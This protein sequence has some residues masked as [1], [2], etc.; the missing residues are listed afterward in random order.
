MH[1]E[2]VYNPELT[3][4][5]WECLSDVLHIDDIRMFEVYECNEI[6]EIISEKIDSA[7]DDYAYT[8]TPTTISRLRIILRKMQI[9]P[10][11]EYV[12]FKY[13]SED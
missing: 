3:T 10:R 11:D 5:E 6:R 2:Q 8:F 9:I 13:P 1:I 4:E 12:W 7:I